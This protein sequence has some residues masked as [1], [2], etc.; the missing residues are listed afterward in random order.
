[1]TTDT[2]RRTFDVFVE[3]DFILQITELSSGERSCRS[4]KRINNE[5]FQIIELTCDAN[6]AR[7]LRDLSRAVI[8]VFGY[9]FEL[10]VAK[11]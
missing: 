1:M 10:F 3:R 11:I 7:L 6:E 8:V 5:N 2:L 9:Q 4:R